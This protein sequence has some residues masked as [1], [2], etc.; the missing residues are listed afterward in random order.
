MISAPDHAEKVRAEPSGFV[1]R[2]LAAI[3][4][5][6][7]GGIGGQTRREQGKRNSRGNPHRE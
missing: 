3:P 5:L 6:R 4:D 2:E 7:A 1:K